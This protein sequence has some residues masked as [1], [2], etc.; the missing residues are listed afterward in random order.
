MKKLKD[1]L[2]IFLLLMKNPYLRF[3]FI[4]D[5][6][7]YA[8]SFLGFIAAI[9]IGIFYN[10]PIIY[11]SIGWSLLFVPIIIMKFYKEINKEK[12]NRNINE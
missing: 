10:L 12:F 6:A 1:K 3:A 7:F 8:Y 4:I 11:I 2:K 5:I 9:N